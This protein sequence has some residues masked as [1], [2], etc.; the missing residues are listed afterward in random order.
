MGMKH[1]VD[2][3]VYVTYGSMSPQL[4]GRTGFSKDDAEII[5]SILPKLFEGDASSARPEGSMAVE[6]VIWW[7]HNCKAGQYS[8][9]RV[10]K[11]L[12]VNPDGSYSFQELDGLQ[13]EIME[14]F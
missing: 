4:A 8:S 2:K 5:K 3:A 14:G 6:K 1:R 9:A 10:H 11:T 12:T 13:P 7:Q